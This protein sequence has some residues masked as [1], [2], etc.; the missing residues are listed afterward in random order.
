M[1]ALEMTALGHPQASPEGVEQ[2]IEKSPKPKTITT[3]VAVQSFLRHMH[4]TRREGGEGK[5][6]LPV[7][8]VSRSLAGAIPVGL[9]YWSTR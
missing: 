5:G 9:K 4:V 8:G 7:A 3:C 1:A 6:Q 2:T